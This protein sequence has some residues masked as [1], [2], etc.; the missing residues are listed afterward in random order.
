MQ[1][2]RAP[3]GGQLSGGGFF[4]EVKSPSPQLS[5]LLH[6]GVVDFTPTDVKDTLKPRAPLSRSYHHFCEDLLEG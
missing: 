3:P 1:G 4:E 6:V 2:W 5:N